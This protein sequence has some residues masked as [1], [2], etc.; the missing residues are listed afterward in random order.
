MTHNP[1]RFEDFLEMPD[2]KGFTL[3]DGKEFFYDAFG[4]WFDEEKN[5]YNSKG[6][7]SSPPKTEENYEDEYEERDYGNGHHEDLDDLLREYEPDGYEDDYNDPYDEIFHKFKYQEKHEKMEKHINAYPQGAEIKIEFSNMSFKANKNELSNFFLHDYPFFSPG[8]S[9]IKSITIDM[10]AK[11]PYLKTGTGRIVTNM[12]D[13]ALFCLK[14]DGAELLGRPLNLEVENFLEE[15]EVEEEVKIV[16]G[17][18]NENSRDQE[19]KK[20][21]HP[22]N[23]KID[24]KEFKPA[25][26]EKEV[27]NES[28]PHIEPKGKE[29]P[30]IVKEKVEEKKAETADPNDPWARSIPKQSEVKTTTTTKPPPK[31]LNPSS[32]SFNQTTGSKP[33]TAAPVGGQPQKKN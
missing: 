32:A 6:Q 2:K 31:K 16:K 26:P 1:S 3:H 11:N 17:D 25:V 5:Y 19:V 4:G 12:K 8:V 29:E 15:F 24:S 28:K 21:E 14:K 22:H 23:V 33:K 20:P 7:P 18:T 30:V 27:K 10:Q 9:P 13:F